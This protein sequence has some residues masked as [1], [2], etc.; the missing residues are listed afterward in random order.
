M[1]IYFVPYTTQ[2][3]LYILSFDPHRDFLK[4]VLLSPLTYKQ[5]E[6]QRVWVIGRL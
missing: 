6:V 1:S 2:C 5:N 3:G 4:L